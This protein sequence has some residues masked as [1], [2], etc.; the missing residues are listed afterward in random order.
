MQYRRG[1]VYLRKKD[2]YCEQYKD[3]YLKTSAT[4][5]M[6]LKKKT[7]SSEFRMQ[8]FVSL[9]ESQF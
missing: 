4:D 2:Y 1:F 7:S 5:F 6:P 3:L 8:G 9:V